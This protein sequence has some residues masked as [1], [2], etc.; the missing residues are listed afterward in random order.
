MGAEALTT[1][2]VLLLENL[3][4]LRD[5]E[6]GH[7]IGSD[8]EGMTVGE[9]LDTINVNAYDP[10]VDYGSFIYGDEWK[11]MIQA[12]KN[13]PTLC[14]MVIQ[15]THIDNAEGGGGG[16]SILFTNDNTGEAV[17]AFRGTAS[18]EWKDDFVG[19]GPTSAADGVSTP[20]QENALEWYQNIY[21]EY[22]LDNY[23][24]TVTGHSKG[25]NKAKYIA[26]LDDSVDRCFSYDGQ[27]FSDEFFDVYKDLIAARQGVIDNYN[28][29]NDFVNI[30]LNDIGEKHYYKGFDIKGFQ[31]NHCPNSFFDFDE[32][33]NPIMV[34]S[35]QSE[36]MKMLDDFL[37]SYL[38]TLPPE[39]KAECL[40]FVGTLVEGGFNGEGMDFFKEMLFEG[41]NNV[42]AG[43]LLAFMVK[44]EQENPEF[45]EAVRSV[46]E[47]CGL[48]KALKIVDAAKWILKW[49][50]SDELLTIA[51]VELSQLPD[52]LIK[53]LADF[54]KDKTGMELTNDELRQLL[55]TI[56][57]TQLNVDNIE[58][59]NGGDKQVSTKD[60]GGILQDWM[61]DLYNKIV[62]FFGEEFY[63]EIDKLSRYSKEMHGCTDALSKQNA[64]FE[65]TSNIG[66][67]EAKINAFLTMLANEVEQEK[68]EI[69][70]L[71]FALDKI[72]NTYLK[73]EE[74]II[75]G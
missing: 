36:E 60:W 38:R 12:I 31:E 61:T 24:V 23:Y 26:I 15:E 75:S 17:V 74:S 40:A 66:K 72:K 43:K 37:N 22:G 46:M 58:I 20:Q 35:S 59:P 33:G 42:I 47:Q 9:Y 51:G 67:N 62:G 27:G 19:G 34:P 64:A 1:E 54:I 56:A 44:Y 30:L 11:N 53:K 70:S 73:T 57:A 49:K 68:K 71:S 63:V 7:L 13:D 14:D 8:C 39:E 3:T 18:Q 6:G 69:E 45:G 5:P 21:D 29:D 65:P 16:G 28:L 55:L 50:Y 25:G 52:W 48:G 32:N 4:Y 10:N 2:E 41:D